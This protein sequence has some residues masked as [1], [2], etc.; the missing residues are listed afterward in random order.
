[1]NGQIISFLCNVRQKKI[2]SKL[3]IA[4]YEI[5]YMQMDNILHSP[6]FIEL[7]PKQSYNTVLSFFERYIY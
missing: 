7:F 5:E 6:H 4:R 3:V 1:M 2:D